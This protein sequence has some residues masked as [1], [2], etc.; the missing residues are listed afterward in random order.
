MKHTTVIGNQV[1]FKTVK[2]ERV[3]HFLN[4]LFLQETR[5]GESLTWYASSVQLER[6]HKITK[7]TFDSLLADKGFTVD[8]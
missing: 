3:C 6:S 7:E 5:N 4:E 1:L 8:G 2:D